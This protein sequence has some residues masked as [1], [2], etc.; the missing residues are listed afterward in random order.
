MS[1]PH[2]FLKWA[3]GKTK[4]LPELLKRVPTKFDTYHEPFLGGGALFFALQSSPSIKFKGSVLS[5]INP[6]LA[7]TYIAVRDEVDGVV[8][9][10]RDHARNHVKFGKEH[11]LCVRALDSDFLSE[12]DCAARMIYLNKTCF[13]GLWRVNKKRQFNV[14]MGKFK[15]MPTICDEDNLIACSGALHGV[16]ILYVGF[17]VPLLHSVGKKDFVYLDPPYVP[18]SEM[19]DFTS[20]AKEGFGPAEQKALALAVEK[21]DVR[22]TQFLLS[23][24][25]CPKV[26]ELYK[27]YKIE[28]VSMRRNINSKAASR[29]A[30]V[31][32]LVSNSK[33]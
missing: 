28:E 23:N 4:L 26:K 27:G 6:D 16:T 15:K 10:L 2:P 21:L 19:S 11:Y 18:L 22:G 14:P 30:I 17:E 12:V 3:G 5:D 25:G 29:G 7:R 24:A 8:K 1:S 9:A 33:T 32:Y 31:E 13:N 20:Y